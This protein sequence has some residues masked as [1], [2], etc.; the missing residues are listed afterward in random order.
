MADQIGEIIAI[1]ET[2]YTDEQIAEWWESPQVLLG[3]N[4]PKDML[5]AGRADDILATL[6]QIDDGV[7]L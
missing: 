6:H 2:M 1:L 5:N 3:G 7:Y 4:V